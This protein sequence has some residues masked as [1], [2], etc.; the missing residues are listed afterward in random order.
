MDGEPGLPEYRV[1]FTLDEHSDE[2][3]ELP[4]ISAPVKEDDKK[5]I[6][7]VE[8]ARNVVVYSV[9]FVRTSVL[10]NHELNFEELSKIFRK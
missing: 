9:M 5:V 7:R 1:S 2:E 3:D 6:L 8:S 4:A 10:E